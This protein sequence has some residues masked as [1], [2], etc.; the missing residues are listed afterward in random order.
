MRLGPDISPLRSST[1]TQIL[2]CLSHLRWN[3][4]YQRPQH[5]LSRAAKTHLVFFLEEPV[6]EDVAEPRLDLHPTPEGV[7]VGVPI[8]PHGMSHEAIVRAQKDML[9]DLLA[10]LPPLPLALW[11]YTPM[12]LE[13][14]R[15]IEADVC[16]YDN[17]D[18]LSA[19]RGAPAP[20]LA[21]EREL[22][23]RADVVFTGGESLYEAKQGR[24]HNVHCFPSSIDVT[25]FSKARARSRQKAAGKNERA[26]QLGFFGV[27]D[28]R[29]DP[30]LVAAIADLRPEWQINMIGPVVKID[31]ASLPQRPN[32][33]WLGPR[34]YQD[35]PQELAGWDVG[36]MPFALNEATRFISPT[37]TPEFLAA[38]L[39]VVCTPIRDVIRPYGQLGLVE[40]AETA[41][42]FVQKIELVL[43]RQ[44]ELWLAEVDAH[45]AQNSWDL[46]WERMNEQMGE[47]SNPARQG[48][49]FA[50]KAGANV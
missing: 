43:G 49:A 10:A 8:L 28:E 24:H 16:V 37:K 38:G 44:R 20:L 6:F 2:I 9:D 40:I 46:T 21:L 11:Y 45:L 17:M 5:L 3:F 12:A 35:L 27:I 14:S 50:A 4:V 30:D 26:P 25:H 23:E 29:M 42:D 32:L 47:A 13:F 48:Y 19:F 31:P 34:S 18:E 33:H 1:P 15:H 7:R 39:P 36:I 22:F 41:E